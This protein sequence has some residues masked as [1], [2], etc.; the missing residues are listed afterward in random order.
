MQVLPEYTT[1]DANPHNTKNN[2]HN[3]YYLHYLNSY[4]CHSTGNIRKEDGL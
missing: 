4:Y 3:I 1:Y 2:P